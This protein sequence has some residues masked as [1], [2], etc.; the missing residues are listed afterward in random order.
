MGREV[1]MRN[2]GRCKASGGQKWMLALTEFENC[3]GELARREIKNGT[4]TWIFWFV[5]VLYPV[6]STSLHSVSQGSP[7][8]VVE[9]SAT[10]HSSV[11]RIPAISRQQ[12]FVIGSQ[13]AKKTT[14]R[15]CFRKFNVE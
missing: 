9:S 12:W 14:A 8:V 6:F 2:C 3:S 4:T 13:I 10:Q 5:S 15:I 7:L 11:G 1:V